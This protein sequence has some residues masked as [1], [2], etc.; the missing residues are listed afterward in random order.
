[1]SKARMERIALSSLGDQS[2]SS[3]VIDGGLVE[4]HCGELTRPHFRGEDH[5]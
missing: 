2:N 4:K 1:M 3:T 5:T